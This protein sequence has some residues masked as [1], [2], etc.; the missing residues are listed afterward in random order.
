M[1][2]AREKRVRP[3]RDDK[4]LTSWNALMVQGLARAA[5]VLGKPDWLEAASGALT[6]IRKALWKED[7]LLATYKD[8]RAH[9]DAYLD[10]HAYLLA[11]LLEMLQA[12]FDAADL[13]W[14]EDLA[15]ILMERFHDAQGG[16]FFFTAHDHEA[17]IHRPKPGP[18]NAT[19]S[20]NAVAAWALHRLA[21]VTGETRCSDAAAGT[22]AL[23]W[24][25][26]ATRPSAFG[27]MLMALEEQLEPP[28]TVI[29]TGPGAA[30][31][32]WRELLD[33]AYLPTTMTLFVPAGEPNLPPPL[34]KPAGASVNA[35]I[36]EGVTCLA[37]IASAD[38]LRDALELPRITR[39]A[40][41]HPR[42]FPT[43]A[44]A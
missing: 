20:G 21:F 3:G 4:I 11:A 19:P 14:A 8:G 25:Q 28:R 43:G 31:G 13:A 1:L 44:S 42:N 36:C 15:G 16:G 9:L 17:L 29:V 35:W 39:L 12:R 6:F 38:G 2:A 24:R 34:A 40:A 33:P 22:V 41:S 5:R 26:L 27:S 10:D 23:F 32:A 18:D 7:R 30:F 37:P